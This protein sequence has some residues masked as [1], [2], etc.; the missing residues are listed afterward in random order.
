MYLT[1]EHSERFEQLAD[2]M[3][4]TFYNNRN[5]ING[6][7]WAFVY[8]DMKKPDE[9][10]KLLRFQHDVW[11]DLGDTNTPLVLLSNYIL[12]DFVSSRKNNHPAG[13]AKFDHDKIEAI[14]K[15]SSYYFET[16][17][18]YLVGRYCAQH[19]NTEMAVR[20]WKRAAASLNFNHS[21]R[22]QA[23]AA[24]WDLGI[25]PGQYKAALHGEEEGKDDNDKET[26]KK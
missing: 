21:G 11:K 3:K 5:A 17:V 14:H 19:G 1:L 4:T 16:W 6:L 9:F 12:E 8:I 22:T 13:F 26:D 24:L 20:Y 7:L 18:D 10:E 25:G 23:C 2:C 15:S